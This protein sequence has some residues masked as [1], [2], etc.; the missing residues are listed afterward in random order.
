MKFPRLEVESELQ[1]LAYTTAINANVSEVCQ[2]ERQT[3]YD[4]TYMQNLIKQ[5]LTDFE[6]K[7]MFIKGKH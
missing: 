4:I 1:L 7:L 3:S 2:T 6:N 5:R